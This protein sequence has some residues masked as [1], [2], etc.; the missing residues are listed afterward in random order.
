MTQDPKACEWV[1]LNSTKGAENCPI[2]PQNGS[3]F[4]VDESSWIRNTSNMAGWK[5]ALLNH[6]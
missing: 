4:G 2:F 3:V 5:G 1:D 6:S